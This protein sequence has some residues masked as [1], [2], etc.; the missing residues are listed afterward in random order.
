[1]AIRVRPDNPRRRLELARGPAARH[2]VDCKLGLS[3]TTPSIRMGRA[4][5]PV[6]GV[7]AGAGPTVNGP[8]VTR[9][10]A[11]PA[12]RH[13]NSRLWPGDHIV[14]AA[15]MHDLDDGDH[16][17]VSVR[18][19]V[20]LTAVISRGKSQNLLPGFYL[21]SAETGLGLVTW[22]IHDSRFVCCDVASFG[23]VSGL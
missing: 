5:G 22:D 19:E 6:A 8:R 12:A 15:E 7:A 14:A 4:P 2:G 23:G 9:R 13:V 21:G 20:L 1:V 16:R 11:N 3:T 17:A 18:S 10:Q